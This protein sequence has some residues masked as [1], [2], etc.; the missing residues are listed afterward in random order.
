[1]AFGGGLFTE[2]NKVLPGAYFNTVSQASTVTSYATNGIVGLIVPMNWTDGKMLHFVC[3]ELEF[4]HKDAL[5]WPN[6][7]Q[8]GIGYNANT[9]IPDKFSGDADLVKFLP[10]FLSD[11]FANATQCYVYPLIGS[12]KA[13]AKT[14]LATAKKYGTR[15][16]DLTIK[17]VSKDDQFEVST[18]L[19]DVVVDTQV[20]A[21]SA[22]LIDNDYVEFSKSEQLAPTS[23]AKLT[24]GVDGGFET[25]DLVVAIERLGD[26]GVN[27]VCP[28]V[29]LSDQTAINA[30][31][32][33]CEKYGHWM[34]MVGAHTAG[35]VPDNGNEYLITPD[36]ASATVHLNLLYPWIAG[37]SAACELGRSLDNKRIDASLLSFLVDKEGMEPPTQKE[38]ERGMQAG[39][40]M[41]H[42]VGGEWR[43]LNDN[44]S[45]IGYPKNDS[46]AAGVT[47]DKN[48]SYNQVIRTLNSIFGDW[49][50]IFEN[51]FAGIA[52]TDEADRVNYKTRLVNNGNFYASKGALKNFDSADVKVSQGKEADSYYVEAFLQP[53]LCV[54]KVYHAITV[55]KFAN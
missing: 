52:G 2:Q 5:V 43:V 22:D 42:T 37:A 3:P 15:G 16:N 8:T 6:D 12:T 17:V 51:E 9:A 33:Q 55:S 24:G 23:A 7:A 53:N 21:K 31:I 4:E 45:Y 26:M 10:A 27:V 14:T 32:D 39:Y 34:Q 36:V 30:V 40:F 38:L 1:M 49:S 54:R 11:I 25:T 44:N 18:L 50:K 20:V 29:T 47:K 41:I 13:K 48:F 35:L 19:G 46:S 28:M